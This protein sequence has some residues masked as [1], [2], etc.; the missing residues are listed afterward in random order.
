M[1]T[2][3][4]NDF[5]LSDRVKNIFHSNL[6]KEPETILQ[7]L[8][9]YKFKQQLDL[10]KEL[11]SIKH[12]VQLG[13]MNP[14]QDCIE[15][16]K[17]VTEDPKFAEIREKYNVLVDMT[18][19]RQDENGLPVIRIIL[20]LFSQVDKVRLELDL[21]NYSVQYVYV[22]YSNFKN[23]VGE[24][25]FEQLYC[26]DWEPRL[27]FMRLVMEAMD[28][29]GTDLHVTVEHHSK[30]PSYKVYYRR[31]EVLCPINL[32]NLTPELCKSMIY[33]TIESDS[34]KDSIDLF[35]AYG[36]ITR[37]HD[38]FKDGT[39][40]LRLS[41]NKVL[42]G[43]D[44]VAR[45]QE[46]TNVT[47]TIETLGF[48][49]KTQKALD[50][51]ADRRAGLTFITGPLRTGKTTTLF[52]LANKMSAAPIKIKSYE[53]PIEALMPFPQI[54]YKSNPDNLVNAIRVAK[55]QDI[56]V[57]LLNEIP[58]KSVAFAVQD[59]VNSSIYVLT[60]LHV[61]R[62]WHIPY[63]LI[64]YYG[65]GYKNIISQING[66]FN[67]KMFAS[68]CDKCCIPKYVNDLEDE[69]KKKILQDNNVDIYY[70]AQ[71]CAECYDLKTGFYGVQLGK[72]QPYCEFL[73]FT[74]E[75]KSKLLQC[76]EP[77]EMEQ[78]IKEEVMK[79]GDSLEHELSVA[80]SKKKLAIT[81]LDSLF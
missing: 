57:A 35:E 73:L 13:D 78:I 8:E 76:A 55:K 4:I 68:L 79:N 71:G 77:Y 67:Q 53:D 43:Y 33:K 74:D 17:T 69:R 54:D 1:R 9:F 23:L 26:F 41:A 7:T 6:I 44:Y 37:I 2:L 27:V 28:L 64:E 25:K 29:G 59:L 30:K 16:V 47:R 24:E 48:P 21:N 72:G 12:E 46:I 56:D 32:F 20:P 62:I 50:F 49:E 51:I 34:S 42:N 58:D 5:N 39:V 38:L 81:A 45:I 65:S 63:K 80:I 10:V 52:A 61:N 66:V 15:L 31:D 70:E 40:E 60:T 36:V 11:N 75:L 3:N 18:E 22:T 14:I 19:D